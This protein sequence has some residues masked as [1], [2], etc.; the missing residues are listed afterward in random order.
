[1]GVFFSPRKQKILLEKLKERRKELKAKQK[2]N[3]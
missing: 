2:T 3:D 1:M